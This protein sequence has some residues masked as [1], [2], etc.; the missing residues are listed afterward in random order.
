[1]RLPLLWPKP[2][3]AEDSFFRHSIKGGVE[4]SRL[5]LS[6]RIKKQRNV[7]F[8]LCFSFLYLVFRRQVRLAFVFQ[9]LR[10]K[11][12][13]AFLHFAVDTVFGVFPVGIAFSG[14]NARQ[15]FNTFVNR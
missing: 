14:G 11:R 5:F 13:Q 3:K 10:Q 12:I 15:D 7:V 8:P 6:N 2:N 4:K 9:I 1:M